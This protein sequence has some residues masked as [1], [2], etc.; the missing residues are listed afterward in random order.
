MQY[1]FRDP[2]SGH[3]EETDGTYVGTTFRRVLG[4]P[5]VPLQSYLIEEDVHQRV[6]H[7]LPLGLDR[8]SVLK[9]LLCAWGPPAILLFAIGATVVLRVARSALPGVSLVLATLAALALWAWAAFWLG[10]LAPE[11]CALRAA[12]GR[13]AGWRFDVAR[14]GALDAGVVA[15]MNREIAA[16][17]RRASAGG[18]LAEVRTPGGLFAMAEDAAVEDADLL[19]VALAVARWEGSIAR[20][21]ARRSKLAALHERLWA[22]YKLVAPERVKIDVVAAQREVREKVGIAVLLAGL[23]LMLTLAWV[24]PVLRR[25]GR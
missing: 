23:G 18:E 17:S 16:R 15:R 21:E 13:A 10:R 12:Y 1:E 5:V 19:E 25:L 11:E 20:G 2:V 8:R 6:G 3:I 22:R 14:V 24:T 4:L 9:A 7:F